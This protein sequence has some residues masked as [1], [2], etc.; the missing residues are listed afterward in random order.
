MRPFAVTVAVSSP[1]RSLRRRLGR[2]ALPGLIAF[3]LLLQPISVF[4]HEGLHELIDAQNDK[5]EKAPSDPALRF[6]LANLYGSHGELE[7]ALKNLGLVDAL[8]P[9]KFQT[10]LL[11]SQAF[12][13]VGDFARAKEA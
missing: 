4:G 2:R 7:M 13:V 5:V 8:A 9:G 10:D 11:R 3:S 12:L 6:E 1:G